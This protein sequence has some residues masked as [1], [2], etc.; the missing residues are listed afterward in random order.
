MQLLYTK[1]LIF[2]NSRFE[3]YH[4]E[5]YILQTRHLY[6]ILRSSNRNTI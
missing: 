2:A 4:T 5:H 3:V 6:L 1:D